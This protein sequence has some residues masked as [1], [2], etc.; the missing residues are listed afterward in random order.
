MVGLEVLSY[1]NISDSVFLWQI[2]W[3]DV[4]EGNQHHKSWMKSF[5]WHLLTSNK[6]TNQ[7]LTINTANSVLRDSCVNNP[8]FQQC[9]HE[10]TLSLFRLNATDPLWWFSCVQGVQKK[11]KK[12]PACRIWQICWNET[13][14][15]LLTSLQAAFARRSNCRLFPADAQQVLIWVHVPEFNFT[16]H[17]NHVLPDIFMGGQSSEISWAFL[18]G[19]WPNRCQQKKYRDL[20]HPAM[21]FRDYLRW[22][23]G[24]SNGGCCV[25]R[26]CWRGKEA[27]QRVCV[28]RSCSS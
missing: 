27:E 20:S 10:F 7:Q 11:K 28:L 15:H 6:S 23:Q 3:I 21:F 25:L 5:V 19:S 12:A 8:T 24:S 2:V 14:V 4:L 17:L 22:W 18:A 9:S 26:K 1:R 16:Q 13:G